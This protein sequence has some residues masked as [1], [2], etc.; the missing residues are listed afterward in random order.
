MRLNHGMIALMISAA[1]VASA[2]TMTGCAS[3]GVIY[4]SYGHDYHRWNRGEDRFYRQW[5]IKTRR[6]HMDFQRR[7]PGDRQAYWDWR[8]SGSTAGHGRDSRR[9]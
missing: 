6:N 2:T 8:H 3:D 9:G 7:S 1:A 4:D 5:E